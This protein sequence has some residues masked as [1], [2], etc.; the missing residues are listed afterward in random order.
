[1]VGNALAIRLVWIRMVSLLGLDK[2]SARNPPGG[3]T[4][5]RGDGAKLRVELARI[6]THDVFVRSE[7][8]AALHAVLAFA[9]M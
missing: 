2:A 5:G 7:K 6:C 9:P 3:N 1:V 4:T 8:G